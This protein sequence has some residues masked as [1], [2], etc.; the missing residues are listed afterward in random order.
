MSGKKA[1]VPLLHLLAALLFE[2]YAECREEEL[3]KMQARRKRTK[4][5]I[6]GRIVQI[7]SVLFLLSS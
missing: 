2:K 4:A 3:K 7:M 5:K 6:A 1:T